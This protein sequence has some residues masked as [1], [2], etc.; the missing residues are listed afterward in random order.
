MRLSQ[1]ISISIY[2]ILYG[3]FTKYVDT[4]QYIIYVYNLLFI[5]NGLITLDVS[6]CF[7]FF[8]F[9]SFHFPFH[10]NFFFL[11]NFISRKVRIVYIL[12]IYII[13]YI[14]VIC[15]R[16]FDV[17]VYRF[18]GVC[19]YIHIHQIILNSCIFSC[20]LFLLFL[21]FFHRTPVHR[22][23]VRASS[24]SRYYEIS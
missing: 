22:I 13:M 10:R 1:N 16:D 19:I 18:A 15:I 12:Y 20:F 4:K 17:Y 2:Q 7:F 3:I 11:I 21:S 5:Q 24:F 14:Y 9:L 8:F 23:G 6:F